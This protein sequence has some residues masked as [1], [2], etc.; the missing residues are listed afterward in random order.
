M[1]HMKKDH[2]PLKHLMPGWF[3]IVMGWCGLALA[4]HRAAPAMG[5]TAASVSLVAAAIA[6]GIFVALS[7]AML[8]R[9]QAH[10]PALREDLAHPVRHT[11]F[12]AIPISGLLL[13]TL[14][15]ALFG[16]EAPGVSALW[17]LSSL[18][19][20]GVTLWVLS[21]W[22]AGPVGGPNTKPNWSAV[23]PVLFIP[24][25]GNVLAPLA[26]L[27]LGH[28]A[29]AA[30]QF[31]LG[32]LFWPAVMVLILVRIGQ[33][34]M[35]PERM[36][37]TMF[38]FVAPPAVVGAGA[39]QFGAPPVLTWML[40]GMALF[41][42]LWAATLARRIASMPFGIPHWGIS[43]PLAALAV[44]TLRLADTPEGRWLQVPA[45]ALLALASLI[46]LGLSFATVRGLRAGTLLVPEG[47]PVIPIQPQ[48]GA[49]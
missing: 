36:L 6:A 21:R 8:W 44:L 25:V 14:G 20:F 24:I 28:G 23:T 17:W 30:A 41:L 47:P 19:Q 26:G 1:S 31:G 5:E 15:V 34:G 48:A 35:P 49:A 38:I 22:I 27:P 46:I 29:W 43:F 12:A 39:M 32:L 11:F 18:A 40:W 16:T 37:P 3:A 10:G 13:A 45:L 2:P 4:W 7:L 9:W 33:A 42:A